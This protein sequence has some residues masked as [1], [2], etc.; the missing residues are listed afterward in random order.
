[1]SFVIVPAKGVP[2]S[3]RKPDLS[4]V[5][6]CYNEGEHLIGSVRRLLAVCDALDLTYETIF[7]DDASTDGTREI[8]QSLLYLYPHHSLR[9]EHNET[10]RGRGFTVTRGLTLAQAPV[11]GFL[12]IDLEVDPVYI[13][14][15]FLAIE[16]GAD[17]A[18]GRRVYKVTVRSFDRLLLSTGYSWLRTQLLG[19]PYED[20]E[21][22]FKFFRVATMRPIVERCEDP[23]WFWDTEVVVRAHR[24]RLLIVEIP[25]LF[26]RR[27]DKTSTVKP[28]RDSWRQL[29]RLITFCR[30]QRSGRVAGGAASAEVTRGRRR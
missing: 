29:L 30:A 8:L 3:A 6:A 19:T 24:A 2:N 12:D 15:F 5:I 27:L 11:A 13:T 25:C 7:V 22:G 18:I 23:G 14:A 20:T 21:A 26:V 16:D 10:N 1:M 9:I 4:L 28:L 17:L